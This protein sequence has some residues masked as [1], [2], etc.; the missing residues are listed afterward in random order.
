MPSQPVRL[1]HGDGC[2]GRD[3]EDN[4]EREKKVMGLGVGEESGMGGDKSEAEMNIL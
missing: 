3:G 2:A 4:R 1:Y